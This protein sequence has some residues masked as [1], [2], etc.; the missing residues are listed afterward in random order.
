MPTVRPRI[1]L[2]HAL[3]ALGL[4]ILFAVSTAIGHPLAGADYE[5]DT[6]GLVPGPS[7]EGW[8]EVDVFSRQIIYVTF[9]CGLFAFVG[10]RQR[11]AAGVS[12]AREFRGLLTVGLILA[13]ISALTWVVGLVIVHLLGAPLGQLAPNSDSPLAALLIQFLAGLGAFLVGLCIV[14][15][16]STYGGTGIIYLIGIFVAVVAIA[17]VVAIGSAFVLS[18]PGPEMDRPVNWIFLFASL[19]LEYLLLRRIFTDLKAA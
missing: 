15:A 6:I 9:F 17:S 1:L 10:T 16:I 5:P 8:R 4:C 18:M 7:A 11:I 19:V 2:T 13:A 3:I 12:R 14:A